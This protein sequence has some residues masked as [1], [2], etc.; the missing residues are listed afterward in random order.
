MD[1]EIA[2]GVVIPAG[3]LQWQ[4]SRAGG[5]GGQHVNTSSSRVQLSWD[6]AGS[7]A[8]DD[9]LR[10]RAVRRL[11]GRLVDGVLTVAASERR[12]QLRNRELARERLAATVAAAIAPPPPRRRATKPTKGSQRRRV[13]AK[14]QRSQT[15][16]L[17]GS[18]QDD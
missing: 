7:P 10:R 14:R 2:P 3:E 18:V 16:R 5:A 4:F 1:L 13:E 6:L 11:G 9:T 8:I 12:S 17:R 15:K